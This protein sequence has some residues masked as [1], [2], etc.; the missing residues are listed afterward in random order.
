M[1]LKIVI[2][3][4]AVIGNLFGNM[5]F[6]DCLAV[7]SLHKSYESFDS[8]TASISELDLLRYVYIP[9]MHSLYGVSADRW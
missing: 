3:K 6:E 4:T 1:F 7:H 8:P 9:P 2:N 5:S